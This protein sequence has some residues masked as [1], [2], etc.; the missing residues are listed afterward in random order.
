MIMIQRVNIASLII[1]CLGMSVS[2]CANRQGTTPDSPVY[3]RVIEMH[4]NTYP[5]DNDYTYRRPTPPAYTHRPPPKRI[6]PS[7]NDA[8][9]RLPRKDLPLYPKK[10]YPRDNDHSYVPP[11]GYSPYPRDNDHYYVPPKDYSPYP[12]DNDN[13]YYSPRGYYNPPSNRNNL[14]QDNDADMNYIYPLYMD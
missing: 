11:R 6:Y 5:K 3:K 13:S 1:L 2:G 10:H 12:Q 8:A 4:H 14:P 9:Y 7:D